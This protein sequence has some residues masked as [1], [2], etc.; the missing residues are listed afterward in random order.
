MAARESKP[1]IKSL[2]I[3]SRMMRQQFHQL[4]TPCARFRKRPL[5]QLLSDAAVAQMAGDADIFE[6]TT[7]GALRAE[8]GQDAELQTADNRT[9]T[10]LC[11]H[12]LE[13]FIPRNAFERIE[14]GLRQRIFEPLARSAEMIVRQ[15]G[16]N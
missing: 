16:D 3:D 9:A 15:H 11:D 4:A 10:I 6:Q 14:I 1:F 5:H 13:I 8:A 12:E 7:R 2:R